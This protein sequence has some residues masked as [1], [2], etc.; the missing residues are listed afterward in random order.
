MNI[1][2]CLIISLS[3][4]VIGLTTAIYAQERVDAYDVASALREVSELSSQLG[5]DLSELIPALD[6]WS[7]QT[8]LQSADQLTSALR[9]IPRVLL[10]CTQAEQSLRAVFTLD[11]ST[12][13]VYCHGIE[14]DKAGIA[15]GRA[16]PDLFRF[17]VSD[18]WNV[19]RRGTGLN[20][21]S[22]DVLAFQ[23]SGSNSQSAIDA[24]PAM[25]DAFGQAVLGIDIDELASS[26]QFFDHQAALQ[27]FVDVL[28]V[29]SA[30][31]A[32][33]IP[34]PEG[35]EP[36][37]IS[38]VPSD[39]PDYLRPP[40]QMELAF[41]PA[42]SA[43]LDVNGCRISIALTASETAIREARSWARS[44]GIDG[45]TY[46]AF[47]RRNTA[48]F[49]GR[50]RVDGTGIEVFVDGRIIVKVGI[51]GARPC[52]SDPNIVPDLFATII[53]NDFSDF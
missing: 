42:A 44:G 46:G 17:F 15:D 24:G 53:A 13:A 43:T 21:C 6:G 10:L 38:M 7:C 2:K 35:F 48:R 52:Q 39:R 41:A 36:D 9:V 27:S 34:L 29:Q 31:L 28:K 23:A 37:E 16:K 12:A 1:K 3:A 40:L 5:E 51:P 49:V 19:A 33:I 47:I 18:T 11:P 50:E 26:D 22:Q 32:A 25:I 20:G 8:D 14:H 45:D 30:F 4:F